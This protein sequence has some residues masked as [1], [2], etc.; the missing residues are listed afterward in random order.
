MKTDTPKTIY[1]RDYKPY[2]F[3]IHTLNMN[4]DL[5]DDHTIVTAT[6]DYERLNDAAKDIFL[7]GEDLELLSIKADGQE[8]TEYTQSDTD[9]RIPT[10][11]DRFTLEIVTKIYPAKNTRLEG[12]Y[13]SGGNFCT[14]CEAEGFR[15][16]TYFPDRPD[17]LTVFTVRIEADKE[18]YPVLLSNGN[19]VDGDET[20]NDRHFTVWEDPFPKP[21]YLFALVAGDLNHIHDSFVTKSGREVDLYIYVRPGDESQCDHAMRSLINSMR[22]DEETY[23]LEYELDVFN[24]VAVSDFNM[25]SMENTS[26]NIFNT[27]LVLA[28]QETA[29]DTDFL[30]VESVIA[31]EYFHNWSGN[32]VT[33]RDWF[34]L[35]LKEGLTVFR[36]QCFSADLNSAMVQRI[37]DVTHLR[38]FQ[39]PEDAGPLAHPIRPDNYIEIN[40]FYT[41]TVYEKGAEVIRM[42]KTIL[43]AENYRKGTDLYFSRHDGTAATCD[44]FIACMEEASGIDL[45]QFKLWY[46]QAGTPR[47]TFNGEYNEAQKRYD[48]TLSQSTPATPNQPT[49]EP[50][51]IPVRVGFLGQDGRELTE[52][53]TFDLTHAEQSFSIEGLDEA[54]TPSI[55][56]GFS[57]PVTLTSNQSNADLSFLMLKDTDGFNRWEASQQLGLRMINAMVDQAEKGEKTAPCPRYID[58]LGKLLDEALDPESDKALLT[59]MLNL[60]EVGFISQSRELVDPPLINEQRSAIIKTIKREHRKVLDKLYKAC[61]QSEYSITPNAMGQRALRGTLLSTLSSTHGTGCERRTKEHY[62]QADNMTDRVAALS[63][64]ADMKRGAREECFA[65]FHERFKDYPLVIDKWFALQACAKHPDVLKHIQSLREHADFNIKNPNR[66]RSLFAAFA[67]NNPVSF[68]AADGSGYSFLADAVIE[69]NAINPQIA[70]RLLTPMREW[71][72]YSE[73]RQIKMRAE[74]ERILSSGDLAPDVYEIASKSLHG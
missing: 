41:M 3:K 11:S 39:F 24:I 1:L 56:R 12:L 61:E 4:F 73:D 46:S 51:H 55:L 23:G 72:R 17:V 57:A 48:I 15:R 37:D 50:M 19:R 21:C 43:G 25:G 28:Q 2:P 45:S 27:A 18:K 31:H 22:W 47:V 14:Q 26:L 63:V 59:R 30:R 8:I 36:D 68:H 58:S 66:A 10:P 40:N 62:E 35:S 70:A 29:T 67:M 71:K 64:L 74:L 53:R 38:R 49:K 69:L 13:M 5:H 20:S 44:D 54:P 52:E 34:Q 60:P 9:L 65:D 16:I 42:M 7:N 6:A 33:C 32:R